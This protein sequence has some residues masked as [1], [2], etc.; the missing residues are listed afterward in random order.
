MLGVVAV[1]TTLYLVIG[2]VSLSSNHTK[3]YGYLPTFAVGSATTDNQHNNL[4]YFSF[5][6]ATLIEGIVFVIMLNWIR[7]IK[8]EFSMLSEL[9]TFAA[10][11]IFFN[12]MALFIVI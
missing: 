5:V 1:S 2:S 10:L 7:L 12:D 4:S 11:W 8:R 9:Q 3:I 6:I